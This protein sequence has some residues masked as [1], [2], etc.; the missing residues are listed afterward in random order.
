MSE[1]HQLVGIAWQMAHHLIF[2]APEGS[3]SSSSRGSF[4]WLEAM[5][6]P[7]TTRRFCRSDVGSMRSLG[8]S[9]SSPEAFLRVRQQVRAEP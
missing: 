6:R 2:Q 7:G 4:H 5:R 3:I 9:L 1:E 8:L